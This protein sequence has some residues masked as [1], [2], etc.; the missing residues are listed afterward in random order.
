MKK[1]LKRSIGKGKKQ[2]KKKEEDE[3]SEGTVKN[4]IESVIV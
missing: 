4:I 1:I 2:L 3:V